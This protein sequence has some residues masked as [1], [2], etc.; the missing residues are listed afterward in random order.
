MDVRGR[1]RREPV[2]TITVVVSGRQR[3]TRE[4]CRAALADASDVR[5]VAE[6]RTAAETLV[7]A[8]RFRPDVVVLA[9][10]LA[11]PE[12]HVLLDALTAAHRPRVL[13]VTAAR[14]D[15][16]VVTALARGARGHV[17]AAGVVRWLARAVGTVGRGGTWYARSLEPEIVARL[18]AHGHGRTG[19]GHTGRVPHAKNDQPRERTEE[20]RGR[21]DDGTH[22]RAVVRSAARPRQP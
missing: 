3:A 16:A 5:V 7:A 6:P 14:S 11:S 10:P 22:H 15:A 17:P 19:G 9:S 4:A 20:V 12:L 21:L 13:L 2:D 1:R 18:V 8:H